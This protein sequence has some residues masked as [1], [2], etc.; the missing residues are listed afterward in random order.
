MRNMSLANA[1]ILF[2][3]IEGKKTEYLHQKMQDRDFV[4]QYF[5]YHMEAARRDVLWLSRIQDRLIEE[6]TL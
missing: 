2:N 3:R 1:E 5:P 4:T 6:F